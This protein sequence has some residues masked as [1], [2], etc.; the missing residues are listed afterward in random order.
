MSGG[1]GRRRGA[2]PSAP[3]PASAVTADPGAAPAPGVRHRRGIRLPGQLPARFLGVALAVASCDVSRA[4]HGS[5]GEW[6]LLVL[7]AGVAWWAAPMTDARPVQDSLRWRRVAARRR[8][9]LLAASAVAAAALSDPPT[10][11]AACVTGLFLAYLLITDDWLMGSTAP[12]AARAPA[13]ALTAA[14]AA[15]LTFVCATVPVASTSWARL[16]AALAL[17]ATVA[18]LALATRG[19]RPRG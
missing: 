8:P 19:R 4:A 13:P 5:A 9:T 1:A 3:A 7:V 15:A 2:G 10:W 14:G 11:L 16:P 18:C 6:L 12:R 17:A